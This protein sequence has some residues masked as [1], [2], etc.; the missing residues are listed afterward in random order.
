MSGDN[1][2]R[3]P[4]A[5]VVR[6]QAAS[7][8]LRRRDYDV[9][10]E[11][12]Q[13][14]LDRWLDESL[15]HRIAYLR[16][17][18]IW[19]DADRLTI[20]R[21]RSERRVVATLRRFIP[22]LARI[23]V[24]FVVAATLAYGVYFY[25]SSPVERTYATGVGE[26]KVVTLADGSRIELNTDT[27]LQMRSGTTDRHVTLARGE[28]YFKITHNARAP[29]VVE[30]GNYRVVDLG[31]EFVLRQDN[32]KLN[33]DLVEGS[34]RF[35]SS[36]ADGSKQRSIVLTSGDAV[37]ATA[38]SLSLKRK[39]ADQMAD[40][41]GWR[42]GMLV[43][44]RTPLAEVVAEYNRYNAQKIEIVDQSI[45]QRTITAT[46]PVND[47]EAFARIAD[48]FFGLHVT[49]RGNNIAVSR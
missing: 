34:A 33:I 18:A 12:D 13:C 36:D 16:L 43:F 37:V 39:S 35:E 28:A 24:S 46:L 32:G 15:A 40:S 22:T 6:A 38:D 19:R 2:A 31:T 8:L 47:I 45:A 17:E 25:I 48:N 1:I 20:L 5:E 49:R 27:S 23:T 42:R 9:W 10:T 30:T 7:W 4:D 44:H 29:F 11:E 3:A 41:L 21:P 14:A 26:H